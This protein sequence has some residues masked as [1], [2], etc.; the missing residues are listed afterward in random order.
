M[1]YLDGLGRTF[2]YGGLIAYVAGILLMV[3]SY[4]NGKSG[5]E[6]AIANNLALFGPVAF[7]GGLACGLSACWL[8]WGEEVLSVLILI[9]GALAVFAPFYLPMVVQGASPPNPELILAAIGKGGYGLGAVGLVAL[10]VD[11]IGR[12]RM[13]ALQGMKTETLRLGKGMKEEVDTRNVFLGRCYQLPFC[14]KFVRERCPIYL[15]KRTCWKERVGCMCEEQVIKD[16]MQGKAI[17]RDV[18]GAAK[19]IP[20]NSRLT[21]QQKAERCR[22]CVIYNEH[23]KHKYKLSIPLTFLVTVGLYFITR[24]P[25]GQFIANA[26][27]RVNG[28]I[29][30]ATL[31]SSGKT[32]IKNQ[33]LFGNFGVHDLLVII[34]FFV[35]FAYAIR[36][37]EW[38]FF[39][40]RN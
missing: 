32:A 4:M 3:F 1:P 16:A 31:D 23:Q 7:W 28:L 37:I 8:F 11:L 27:T 36:A 13:R 33:M 10:I 35:G 25:A 21:P 38:M 34:L 2:F 12:V 17:P 19:Y 30:Q 29:N 40:L 15:A 6:A 5:Q 18:V 39:R 24:E 9:G 20:K 14:R 22:Q 26:V